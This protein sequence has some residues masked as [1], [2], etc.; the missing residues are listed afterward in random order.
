MCLDIQSFV[1]DLD[2][3]LEWPYSSNKNCL[4]SFARPVSETEWVSFVSCFLSQC[5]S[6]CEQ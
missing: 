5:S 2:R 6:G 4:F 3:R 1:G